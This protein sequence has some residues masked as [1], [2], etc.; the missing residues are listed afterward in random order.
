[1]QV[2]IWH[3]LGLITGQDTL[4]ELAV[5]TSALSRQHICYVSKDEDINSEVT[6]TVVVVA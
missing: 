4:V 5:S 3:R 1:M 2:L 6:W